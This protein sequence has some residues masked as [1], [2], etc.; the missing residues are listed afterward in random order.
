MQ[1]SEHKYMMMM[2]RE[3][4]LRNGKHESIECFFFLLLPFL[5][6]VPFSF[7]GYLFSRIF[8]SY[9]CSAKRTM[10]IKDEYLNM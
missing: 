5:S 4:E 9:F 1:K 7:S 6:V 3:E 8:G 10:A 2:M